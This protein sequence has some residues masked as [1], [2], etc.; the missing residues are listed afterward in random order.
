MENIYWKH[1]DRIDRNSVH[2]SVFLTHSFQHCSYWPD[3][4]NPSLEQ[5][6]P[7]KNW[8]QN[9]LQKQKKNKNKTH[10]RRKRWRFICDSLHESKILGLRFTA[11]T[12]KVVMKCIMKCQ[13]WLKL[14]YR[15]LF[16]IFLYKMSNSI[17]ITI[18]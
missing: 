15:E 17:N 4:K 16:N 13:K 14:L 5:H 10:I 18:K 8:I 12:S 6:V 7:Y 11:F 9:P 3:E 2:F 1:F